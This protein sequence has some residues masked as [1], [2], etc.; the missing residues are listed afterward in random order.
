LD[1]FAIAKV[2]TTKDKKN[3]TK[4][5]T[6]RPL[7][8][9]ARIDRFIK[10]TGQTVHKEHLHALRCIGNLGT[11]KNVVSREELLDT[12]QVYEHAL[13]ESIGKK[14]KKI[15]KLAKTLGKAKA[16]P[17]GIGRVRRRAR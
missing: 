14:S 10:A 6:M 4:R 5:G 15:A 13:D 16:S 17:G 7:D 9:S 12:F 1:H 11:Y 8:L 2:H 3:P